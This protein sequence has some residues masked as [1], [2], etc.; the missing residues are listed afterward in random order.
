MRPSGGQA[1]AL[2]LE[3]QLLTVAER[4]R[5]AVAADL[6]PIRRQ[7]LGQFLTPAPVASFLASL[8]DLSHGYPEG[9]TLL[10]PGAGVGSLLA[11]FVDRWLREVG[12]PPLSITAVEVEP[13]L[14]VPLSATLGACAEG[15]EISGS[16]VRDDF[17]QWATDQLG[18]WWGSGSTFD[19]VIMNPPYHKIGSGS[20]E[21]RLL[22]GLGVE[23][24]N[25]YAAFLALA[26]RLLREG[27]QLVA[28]TPRSFTNG[29]YFRAFRRDLLKQVAF[30]RIHVYDTRDSA[31]ADG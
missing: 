20:R 10:D 9:A 30:S 11:A 23:V 28:I 24:S 18:A 3:D 31:F 6:D 4:K 21:R 1:V 17:V 15:T 16:L 7:E 5:L 29:P 8:F 12:H 26:Y 14:H 2:F 27:G 25:I 22:S 13:T 19:F